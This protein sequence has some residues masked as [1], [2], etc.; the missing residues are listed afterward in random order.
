VDNPGHGSGHV[1][2]VPFVGVAPRKY[3]QLFS[4]L[5]RKNSDGSVFVRSKVDAMP[6]H[7]RPYSSYVAEEFTELYEFS[8]VS[9][10]L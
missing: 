2:F 1:D 7:F 9:K 3:M 4:M 8:T 5:K 6:R 10:S